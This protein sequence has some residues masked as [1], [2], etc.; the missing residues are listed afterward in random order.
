MKLLI[1]FLFLIAS[2]RIFAQPYGYSYAKEITLLSSRVVGGVDLTNFPLLITFT[3]NDLRTTGN[4]GHVT[5]N[6]GYDIIFTS[7]DCLTILSHE[8]E[9]YTA[10]NGNYRAWVRI[11]T[12]GASSNTI[13]HMYYGNSS[14]STNPSTNAV[15]DSDYRGVWHFSGNFTD[16]TANGNNLTNISTTNTGTGKIGNARNLNNNTNINSSDAT[17]R[18][19]RLPNGFFAGMTNFTFEGW[20][21]LDRSDTNWE[22]IFDFGTGTGT[23]FFLCPSVGT[24]SP[25]Q[26]R[27]RI[28]IGGGGA[29][30]GPI[31]GNVTN[32]GGNYIHWAVVL[33]NATS[34][35]TLYR[36]GTVLANAAGS[37]TLTPQNLEASTANYFGRSQYGA[38][39]YIDALFDEFRISAT[40]RSAGWIG[41]SYNNQDAPAAS[42]TISSEVAAGVL[43]AP[44]PIELFNFKATP[45]NDQV[46]VEWATLTETNNDFF[47]I[48]RSQNGLEW[49]PIVS[50][51][52][53]GNSTQ[54]LTYHYL[55]EN[56]LNGLSY[57]RLLQTDYDGTSTY[58][59]IVAVNL[60]I[61][62]RV[63]IY[64][65]TSTHTLNVEY[66]GF[67]NR[68]YITIF[69]M[70]GKQIILLETK[71]VNKSTF[72]TSGLP[73]GV[74]LVT[75]NYGRYKYSKKVHLK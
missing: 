8:I 19:L 1:P 15:W 26:T 3:S 22:R 72:D 34:S 33:N 13:I 61:D 65:N 60:K 40:P 21:R 45:I 48:E 73:S 62:S 9:S 68:A 71:A 69:N 10:T 59:S 44:L 16:Y 28:T 11:P 31:S 25:E 29:E 7:D 70:V 27:A 74:Y 2:T 12:L 57:Y 39:H 4:G 50:I 17:G 38:D 42:Y 35:M 5:N 66:D 54:K 41:T 63:T 51:P 14:V 46:N 58:S 24:G 43:C 6:N 67:D 36:N 37:V 23:N 53:G 32:T 47:T 49:S 52:G 30:Q 20:V 18:H 56:P 55:D 64:S 75:V